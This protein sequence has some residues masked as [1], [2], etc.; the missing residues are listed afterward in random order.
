MSASVN[1]SADGAIGD[2]KGGSPPADR[3]DTDDG[4]LPTNG[5]AADSCCKGD[6]DVGSEAAEGA[7]K[8]DDDADSDKLS[9]RKGASKRCAWLF[10][11][12]L[13]TASAIVCCPHV[14]TDASR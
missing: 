1:T 13:Q 5:T 12:P 14:S 7:T 8:H 4:S 2:D 6:D 9:D 11:A 3:T 10:E